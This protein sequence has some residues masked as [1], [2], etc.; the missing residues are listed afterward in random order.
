[1]D[2]TVKRIPLYRVHKHET[3]KDKTAYENS[4]IKVEKQNKKIKNRV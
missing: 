2:D 3:Y 4:K 1:M